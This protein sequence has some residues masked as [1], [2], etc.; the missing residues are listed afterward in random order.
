MVPDANKGNAKKDDA[1]KDLDR[2]R[3]FGEMFRRWFAVQQ[4]V[5]VSYHCP[6]KPFGW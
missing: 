6:A 3:K 5:I 2:R 1:G 4:W